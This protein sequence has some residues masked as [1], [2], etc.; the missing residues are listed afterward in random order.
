MGREALDKS[1]ISRTTS[2]AAAL[3]RFPFMVALICGVGLAFPCGCGQKNE[4]A[5]LSTKEQFLKYQAKAEKGEA[6]SQFKLAVCYATSRGV[7]QNRMEA[8][9]WCRKAAEQNVTQAQ[10]DL[11][12]CYYKGLGAEKNSTEAVKWFRK[13]AQ[14]NL[15]LAQ[16]KLGFCYA[17]GQGVEQ[18]YTEAVKWHRKAAEQNVG[19]SQFFLGTCYA[20]GQGVAKDYMEAYAW[21]SLASARDQFAVLGRDGLAK[22]LSP[23]QIIDANKRTEE[24]R[25]QIE[26]NLKNTGK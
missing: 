9:K 26:A 6:G 18:N 7:E 1:M 10:C 12:T 21:Y 3:L 15:A 13:A 16:F 14:Q 5:V 25:V 22:Q 2:S 24:L 17:N 4:T 19:E 20:Y 8:V 11:G 23:Q